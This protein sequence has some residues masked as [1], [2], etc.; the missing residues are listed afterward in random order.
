MEKKDRFS[1][2]SEIG[3]QRLSVGCCRAPAFCELA[4]PEWLTPRLVGEAAY[5]GATRAP[6]GRSG[7]RVA[8]LVAVRGNLFQRQSDVFGHEGR[9]GESAAQ[10]QKSGQLG[11]PDGT[12]AAPSQVNYE[13][14]SAAVNQPAFLSKWQASASRRFSSRRC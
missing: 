5:A 9:Q 8:H 3:V 2:E 10:G 11:V 1:R 12:G 7:R 14:V 6:A 13:A 4:G